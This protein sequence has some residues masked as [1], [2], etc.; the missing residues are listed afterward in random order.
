MLMPPEL[1]PLLRLVDAGQHDW[2]WCWQGCGDSLSIKTQLSGVLLQGERHY[3]DGMRD[4]PTDRRLAVLAVCATE[5]LPVL[6]DAV[7]ETHDSIV[8]KL[9]RTSERLCKAKVS[10]EKAAIRDTL[11]SFA[12]IGSA[13]V[14]AQ[15]HA[16]FKHKS[17]DS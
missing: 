14:G 11:K 9:Y 2:L 8:G 13:L 15:C 4:L 5:W 10:D 1:A 6:A 17:P 3:A 16:A 7:I 12:D